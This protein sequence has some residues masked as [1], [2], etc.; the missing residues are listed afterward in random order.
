MK[1]KVKK[2]APSVESPNLFFDKCKQIETVSPDPD[3]NSGNIT[4]R[5]PRHRLLYE[6]AD[7]SSKEIVFR[8]SSSKKDN[9]LASFIKQ[10]ESKN[11][12]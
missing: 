4:F 9:I 6:D 7:S 2:A 5:S 12:F 10:D 8:S 3:T 11:V 1:K